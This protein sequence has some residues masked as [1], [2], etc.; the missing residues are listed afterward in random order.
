LRTGVEV[1]IK[2]LDRSYRSL[3]PLP[4]LA[5]IFALYLTDYSDLSK[6]F[7]IVALNARAGEQALSRTDQSVDDGKR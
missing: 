2:E 1:K 4:S 3:E 6:A 5:Q 7:D